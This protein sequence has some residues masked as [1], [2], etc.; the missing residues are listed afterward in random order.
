MTGVLGGIQAWSAR[1]R[2]AA[3]L[4]VAAALADGEE[5]SGH[6]LSK[7]TGMGTDRLYPTLMAMEEAG[8]IRSRWRD[9][10]TPRT[11][12]YSLSTGAA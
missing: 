10:P 3:K 11:R 2:E 1:R 7:T 8:E 9:G 4:R 5:Q 12:L 6:R